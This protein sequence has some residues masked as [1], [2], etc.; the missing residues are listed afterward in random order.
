MITFCLTHWPFR[1]F[2]Y[3]IYEQPLSKLVCRESWCHLW[4]FLAAKGSSSRVY[5]LWCPFSSELNFL[6]ILQC[7]VSVIFLSVPCSLLIICNGSV[8]PLY[9]P[10]SVNQLFCQCFHSKNNLCTNKNFNFKFKPVTLFWFNFNYNLTWAASEN[11]LSSA[12]ND[13]DLDNKRRLCWNG[14]CSEGISVASCLHLHQD[15]SKSKTNSNQ[16]LL[17]L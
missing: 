8:S 17:R 5:N 3:M 6:N 10:Y 16:Y 4:Y 1:T 9:N 2:Y 15:G 14:T 7:S 13:H 12:C 11:S